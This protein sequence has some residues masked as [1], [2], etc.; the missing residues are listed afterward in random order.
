MNNKGKSKATADA[1]TSYRHIHLR[2][3][4]A[5]ERYCQLK[6]EAE[7]QDFLEKQF[8]ENASGY[9][10]RF[11]VIPQNI[12]ETMMSQYSRARAKSNAELGGVD[13]LGIQRQLISEIAIW[14]LMSNR[15]AKA[16][17]GFAEKCKSKSEEFES[18]FYETKDPEDMKKSGKFYENY[19]RFF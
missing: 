3:H 12:T 2:Q 6:K 10:N 5:V 4:Y 11:I 18:I 15:N 16:C 9:N 17:D 14:M 8:K 7:M 1:I 19:G 13:D